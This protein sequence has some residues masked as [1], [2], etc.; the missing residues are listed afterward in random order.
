MAFQG[1]EG[2]RPGEVEDVGVLQ[3]TLGDGGAGFGQSAREIRD[4]GPLPFMGAGYNLLGKGVAS[5]ALFE[6]LTG[7][8]EARGQVFELFDEDHMVKPRQTEEDLRGQG[9]WCSR[10]LQN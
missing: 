9:Q 2:Q 3:Q 5:P 1:S 4:G 10:L 7:I 8:P 6:C